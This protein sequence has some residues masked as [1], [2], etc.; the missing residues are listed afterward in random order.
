MAGASNLQTSA[1]CGLRAEFPPRRTQPRPDGRGGGPDKA[2]MSV[3]GA[4]SLG[5]AVGGDPPPS[6]RSEGPAD[7]GWIPVQ[8]VLD[9]LRTL[10][11]AAASGA[12]LDGSVMAALGKQLHRY[13]PRRSAPC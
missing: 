13:A 3:A 1:P 6:D 8:R 4:P 11:H 5:P 9:A 7:P 2:G 10:Q 12:P